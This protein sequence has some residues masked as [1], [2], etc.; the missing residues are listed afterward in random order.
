[1]RTRLVSVR[2]LGS[3]SEISYLVYLLCCAQVKE[4]CPDPRPSPV[5]HRLTALWRTLDPKRG[6]EVMVT[7]KEKE[8]VAG[9]AIPKPKRPKT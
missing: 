5:A 1:M 6:A 2:H 3:G 7:G 4:L 8:T 9:K